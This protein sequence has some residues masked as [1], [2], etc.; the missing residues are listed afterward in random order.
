MLSLIQNNQKTLTSNSLKPIIF[1][2]K[3]FFFKNQNQNENEKKTISILNRK[4]KR[5]EMIK[6]QLNNFNR[7]QFRNQIHGI[8]NNITRFFSEM[9]NEKAQEEIIKGWEFFQNKDYHQAVVSLEKGMNQAQ[10]NGNHDQISIASSLLTKIYLYNL[11]D[12]KEASKFAQIYH[13]SSEKIDN[14]NRKQESLSLFARALHL[15]K[16]PKKCQEICEKFKK[17]HISSKKIND[18]NDSEKIT[19]IENQLILANTYNATK[20]QDKTLEMLSESFPVVQKLSSSASNIK[21]SFLD[22]YFKTLILNGKI[23]E[24]IKLSHEKIILLEE[25]KDF[26]SLGNFYSELGMLQ[27]IFGKIDESLKFLEKSLESIQK[28]PDSSI[29]HEIKKLHIDVL[30]RTGE[31]LAY[32]QKFNES[33][34]KFEQAIEMSQKI[35]DRNFEIVSLEGLA[36]SFYFAKEHQKSIQMCEKLF[37]LYQVNIAKSRAVLKISQSQANLR[38]FEKSIESAK[39]GLSLIEYGMDGNPVKKSEEKPEKFDEEKEG[40]AYQLLQIIFWSELGLNNFKKSLDAGL[41][42][43]EISQRSTVDHQCVCGGDEESTLAHRKLTKLKILGQTN[44]IAIFAQEFQIA[45]K[46]VKETIQLVQELEPENWDSL[47]ENHSLLGF[48]FFQTKKYQESYDAFIL[49]LEDDKKVKKPDLV[50]RVFDMIFAGRC[51]KNITS[52]QNNQKIIDLH[53]EILSLMK[54]LNPQNLQELKKS[55]GESIE[56]IQKII[57][58]YKKRK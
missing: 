33:Y 16:D 7:N 29:N 32:L 47:R 43:L 17:N 54:K 21:L 56:S 3:P 45:E 53:N 57:D 20:Q 40:V 38:E 58:E 24:M 48:L 23:E 37:D 19:Q 15:N 42:S 34:P 39:K 11:K 49:G 31:S 26:V 6:N 12:P 27:R 14:I 1:K 35:K 52:D 50:W 2:I 51:L 41:A 22:V 5:N 25:N 10:I 55:S 9:S 36:N 4:N 30:I 46:N 28:I 44:R 13:D 18:L 8:N